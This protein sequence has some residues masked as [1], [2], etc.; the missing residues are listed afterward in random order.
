MAVRVKK[1]AIADIEIKKKANKDE[2]VMKASTEVSSLAKKVC[3][4]H[5]TL[6]DAEAKFKTLSSELKLSAEEYL[7]AE[8][9]VAKKCIGSFFIEPSEGE[10][11]V[12]II[13]TDKFSKIAPDPKLAKADSEED[14]NE[15]LDT[16]S[17]VLGEDYSNFVDE[18]FDLTLNTAFVEKVATDKA[19]Y[20]KF[21]EAIKKA[22]FEPKEVMTFTKVGIVKK[23]ALDMIYRFGEKAREKILS[24]CKLQ[25]PS[26]KVV[27][28]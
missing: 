25:E 4:A 13:P 18:K 19:I 20:K 11:R 1:D 26:L 7:V 6:K 14:Y 15:K 16:I 17:E 2:L 3:D 23:G 9:L 24:I 27:E 10:L 28:K 8:S 21:C 5:K 22:G 12:Q